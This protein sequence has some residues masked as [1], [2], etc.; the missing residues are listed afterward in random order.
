MSRSTLIPSRRRGAVPLALLVALVFGALAAPAG[1]TESASSDDEATSPEVETRIVGGSQAP[2]GAWPSQVALI[3][4]SVGSNYDGQFCG[5]TLISRSWVLTA[6]HCLYRPTSPTTLRRIAA[7]E[8]DV[9]VGT[10]RL[11]SG[12]TRLEVA[13][14]RVR[15]DY[16]PFDDPNDLALLRLDRPAPASIPFQALIGQD[17]RITGGTSATATGWGTREFAVRDKPDNLHQATFPVITDRQCRDAGYG[18]DI[19]SASMICAGRWPNGKD[20][21]Q[22]DSGGPLV[23][24]RDGRWVQI[25]ITSF[26]ME[27]G[28]F[29]GVY[30][31]VSA[32][33]TWIQQQIRYGP[34]PEA[35]SF[36]RQTYRDLFNRDATSTE[37]FNSVVA[38]NN[39]TSASVF[40]GDLIEGVAYQRRVGGVTRLYSAFFLR[41]PDTPGMAYWWGEVNGGRSLPRVATIMAASGEFRTRY[42]YLDDSDYVER[43]YQ[44]VLGRPSDPEGRAFWLAELSSGRRTRG[45]VMVGF[46]EASEYKDPNKPRVDV[47]ISFFGLVRR[48]PSAAELSTWTPRT[49][50]A[51]SDFLLGSFAYAS[52]F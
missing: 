28:E 36:V 34:H 37:V 47:I 2:A 18:S 5:G 41:N 49:N 32:Y 19:D 25:G 8:V 12:G 29:P 3:T 40:V 10:Q 31:K 42:G 24:D 45:G 1:A 14:I 33:S 27:C 4:S 48:V 46:S 50:L 11:S 9:L 43:V 6:G 17:T 7:S 13:E 30:T 51:L 15:P 26:G 35:V 21:C 39:G 44:N 22:G 23:T 20:T 38:L 16:D 52:R